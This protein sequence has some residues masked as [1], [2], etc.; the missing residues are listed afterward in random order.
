VTRF[1]SSSGRSLLEA[2]A[3]GVLGAGL[4]GAV[5]AA[6][7]LAI[8]FAVV[9]GANGAICGWRRVY[10]LGCSTG[11]LA[12]VLDSTWALPMTAAGLVSQ[13]L[14]LIRGRPDYDDSTSRRANR[15]VFGRGF[16]PR[17]GFAITVGNVISGAGDTS[18]AHRR[19]LVT[20]HEDVHVWQGRW[21]G[22]VY[23]VLYGSW[24]VVGGAAGMVVW[25]FGRRS[26]RFSKVVES[27]AYY[28]N[29][30]EWWAYSRHGHWPPSG[31][32]AGLGWKRPIVRPF[33]ARSPV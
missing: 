29:P 28:L 24:M 7:D 25:L 2:A 22:P 23:P 12:V 27:C 9:G 1:G 18:L 10:D 8:P 33:A 20:D 11:L 15:Q 31:K 13:G 17:R 6:F 32:V 26:E 19:R 16:V 3:V 5:G 21:L 4:A 30:F 14:G